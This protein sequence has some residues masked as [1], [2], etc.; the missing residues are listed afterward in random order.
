MAIFRLLFLSLL[1][2]TTLPSFAD[3][4]QETVTTTTTTPTDTVQETVVTPA[5]TT[6]VVSTPTDTGT[7]TIV[8]PAP[9]PKEAVVIPQGYVECKVIKGRWRKSVWISE[10]QQCTYKKTSHGT[11]WVEGHWTCT[12]HKGDACTTWAWKSGYW[13]KS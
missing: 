5:P 6:T 10:H 3:T 9:A 7:V 13:L 4:V 1:L 12:Q 11:V 2:F 8:T